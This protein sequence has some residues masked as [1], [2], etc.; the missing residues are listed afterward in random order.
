[1]HKKHKNLEELM[2]QMERLY[3]ALDVFVKESGLEYD[4]DEYKFTN[5]EEEP[6]CDDEMMASIENA[7]AD[8]GYYLGKR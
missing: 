7:H 4:L 2:N 3:E 1:M 5:I 6:D 8:L